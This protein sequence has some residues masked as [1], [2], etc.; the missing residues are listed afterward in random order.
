MPR[1]K[2]LKRIIRARVDK[3]G[4]AYTT[5]RSHVV[6][7][8]GQQSTTPATPPVPPAVVPD[9]AA[10]AGMSDDKVR[11]KTGRGW[12]G[13]THALDEAGAA[14]L[15][16]GAIARIVH[17][18]FEVGGW[19]AQTVT[20]GYER[21][22]GLRER[23]QRRSGTW[24]VSKS[25]TFAVPVGILFDACADDRT[26]S[27]WLGA[28]PVVTTMTRPRTIRIRWGDG[29]LVALYFTDKGPNKSVVTVQHMKLPDR[30][31]ADRLKTHWTERL[32]ALQ[33]LLKD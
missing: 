6:D 27:R 9:Y 29:T 14:D 30:D 8:S 13:W 19:W 25:R 22:K 26:R 7:E 12:A 15:E 17:E 28:D 21:I 11:A 10:L 16:H 20:V 31:T 33:A 1:D 18:R 5:A 24:E 4:E 2:D 23:G 32:D 3:T